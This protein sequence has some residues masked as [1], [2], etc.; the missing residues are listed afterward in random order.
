MILNFLVPME[1][2]REYMGAMDV[3][4][5]KV[6]CIGVTMEIKAEDG[7]CMRCGRYDARFTIF[8]KGLPGHVSICGDCLAKDLLERE[9][10]VPSNSE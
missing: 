6:I 4:H 10:N 2:Q 5:L 9:Q 7:A 3:A 8:D 1:G